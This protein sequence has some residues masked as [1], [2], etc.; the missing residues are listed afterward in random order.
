MTNEI[1]HEFTF[2]GDIVWRPTPE[3]IAQTNVKKFMDKH[4]IPTFDALIDRSTRDIGWFWRAMQDE[5][6]VEFYEPYTQIVDLS[7]GPQWA[8]WCVGGKM[9]IVHNALDKYIGTPK[10]AQVA[11]KWEGEEGATRTLTYGEL[12]REVNK[13]AHA[14]RKLGLKKGDAIGIF[15]PMTPEIAVALLAIA[16]IGAVIL[17]LFSGYGAGAVVARLNDAGAKALFTAD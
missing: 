11:V 4:A 7:R 14:L 13:L 15:M 9:N 17:P 5:M 16:K 1:E 8:K 12:Y 10:E 2:G 6:Q 3:Q